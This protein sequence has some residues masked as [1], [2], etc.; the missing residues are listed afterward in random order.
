FD[1]RAKSSVRQV[2]VD[3]YVDFASSVLD[4][5]HPVAPGSDFAIPAAFVGLF[6]GDFDE[7]GY[8]TQRF[9]EAVLAKPAPPGKTFPYIS[10]DSWGYQE[11]IDEETLRHNADVAAAMGVEL[12]IVDLGWARSIGDWYANP[13]K[14]PN[15]LGGVSDYVH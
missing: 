2:G 11:Q 7:A 10:W 3:G 14:F 15:G 13:E 5:N 1:G 12:F 8:R 4:L 9:V 6:H